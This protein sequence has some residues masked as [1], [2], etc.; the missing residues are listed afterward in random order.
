MSK[1]EI[2]APVGKKES[3]FVAVNNGADAIY[4]G[5]DEFN[6][7]G[8]IENFTLENL[9][10][11]V[12]YAHLYNVK[13]YLTLNIL[14]KDSEFERVYEILKISSKIGVDAFI[15]QDIGLYY[16][17]KHNFPNLEIHAST[18]MGVE[19]YEGAKFIKELGYERVVL[20]RESSLED[21][22][23]IKDL[24]IDIEYFVQGAL[25]VA[26]SGN[27]YLC[28][29]LSGNSGNRGKCK[30]LC[31][32]PYSLENNSNKVQGYLL[33]TKDFCML[34][35]LKELK[36]AGVTSFKIEGRARREGYIGQAVNTYRK[37]VD[38][39][40]EFNEDD[41][42]NLKKV[43]NRGDY[44]CGYF[45]NKNIIYNKAQNHIGIEIG[46]VLSINKGKK[47]NE[48]KIYSNHDFNKDD[49]IKFFVD[50]KE[51]GIITV[52]DFKKL[53]KN[54]Y[55]LTTTNIIP[56]NSKV[57]LIVDSES[58]KK[59]IENKRRI[60]V[61]GEIECKIGLPSKLTLK[62]EKGIFTAYGEILQEG[63]NHSL[64]EEECFNQIS[65]LGDEFKLNSLIAKLERVFMAK[66]QLNELRRKCVEGLKQEILKN[67]IIREDL[68]N[69]SIEKQE[70]IEIFDEKQEKEIIYAITKIEDLQI[71]KDNKNIIIFKIQ[72]FD[73]D[74]II[75]LYNDYKDLKIYLDL[76]VIA[77]QKEVEKIKE[78]LS[79]CQNFGVVANN[80]YALN[81]TS[82]NK[83][84]IGANMN[85]YNSYTVKFYVERGYKRIIV[86][87]EL[88]SF[89]EIK[90]NGGQLYYYGEYYPEYMHF[91]HCPIKDNIGGDCGHCKFN[92]EYKYKLN[93]TMFNL[94]RKR[95]LKCQFVLKSQNKV[96]RNLNK[97][98][99]KIIEI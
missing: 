94:V 96:E 68:H 78:V 33:S 29:L 18:Q 45:E 44:I 75:D 59:I 74:K 17:I 58:E 24:N 97:N 32:L 83:T 54:E 46:R 56:A 65:K 86:S 51:C 73:K 41:I 7:R 4:L 43:Y 91:N 1:V 60:L 11:V 82:K 52:K 20:A 9:K 95:I 25:C 42:T 89:D 22:K 19:N 87:N 3:L 37:V 5:I 31:R 99:S 90:S 71:I 53:S 88:E 48:I 39:N 76:P 27:C 79:L 2:L 34:P 40:F 47:F 63:K 93:N 21:I 23:R 8:N 67:Y 36:S 81:L 49:V 64:T 70:K 38:N 61:E 85:V 12:E 13:V 84:I 72:D 69:K 15:I 66:S 50:G 6:A 98:F 55:I 14:F 35:Y 57:R 77:T 16:F 80:Y 30:Q 26:F 28:S 92:G 62:T 10:E